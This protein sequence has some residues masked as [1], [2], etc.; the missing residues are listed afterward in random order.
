MTG[1]SVVGASSD[2]SSGQPEQ[3][4][5]RPR[6]PSR[7]A[8][9]AAVKRSAYR[10]FG[11][12]VSGARS[13]RRPAA[14]SPSPLIAPDVGQGPAVAVLVLNVSLQA[15]DASRPGSSSAVFAE[16]STPKHW[17]GLRRVLRLWRVDPGQPHGD[18]RASRQ[19]AP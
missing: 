17:T 9:A 18:G 3:A 19:A 14:H 2:A 7:A 15:D 8:C 5:Q 16:A 1:A 13:P 10:T 6:P 12:M 4:V 11:G